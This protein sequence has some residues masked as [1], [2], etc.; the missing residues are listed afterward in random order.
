[1]AVRKYFPPTDKN[2]I[3]DDDH[4]IDV[5]HRL[6]EYYDE[7]PSEDCR[8]LDEC[9]RFYSKYNR[10]SCAQYEILRKIWHDISDNF[11]DESS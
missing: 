3:Y 5:M 4:E 7:N 6:N 10:I 1:M 11:V 2:Y 9:I 8:Y